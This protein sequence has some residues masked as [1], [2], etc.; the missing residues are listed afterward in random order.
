MNSCMQR[1]IKLVIFDCDGTLVDSQHNIT[2]AMTYAFAAHNLPAPTV[3][4]VLSIVGLSLP[5]TFAVLAAEH[6]VT[7]QRAYVE[8]DRPVQRGTTPVALIA[9]TC[10][11][12]R[13]VSV[14]CRPRHSA[15][16]VCDPCH[17]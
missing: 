2:A 16:C 15:S 13:M 6:P 5:E 7:L 9:G 4:E 10:G 1:S 12:R 17:E 11:P 3:P 8:T 14:G